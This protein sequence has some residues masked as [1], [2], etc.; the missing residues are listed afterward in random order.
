MEH[1]QEIKLSFV[2]PIYNVKPYLKKCVDSLLNQ[3]YDNY[4][5]ILV[6][7]GST[8]GS[9]LLADQLASSP[10]ASSPIIRVIH[11][12]NRGLSAAR[13]SGIDVAQGEYICFV[14]SDDYWEPNVLGG[15]MAQI[16]RDKLDVLRFKW[17]NVRLQS[18]IINHQSP[19]YEVFY[20]YKETNNRNNF[21]QAIVDGLTFLNERMSDQCYAW[22]FILKKSLLLNTNCLFTEGMLFEDTDWT[23]RMLMQAKRVASTEIVVYSYLWR[24]NG[25][26]LSK[27]DAKIRK[28][29]DDKLRLLG[30]LKQ[31][32][33]GIWYARMIAALVVSVVGILS[34]TMWI[35][36]DAY[37]NRISAL[38]VLPLTSGG[39]SKK[40]SRKICLI[41]MNLKL[42]VAM[43]HFK[44]LI[45][46][47]NH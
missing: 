7:D 35:D 32:N 11:Q 33:C 31:W 4:E 45:T 1:I 12:E 21:S 2:V 23:P 29:L 34:D 9:G 27:S 24:E 3:D 19:I 13:N 28:E 26:T 39:M 44:I 17:Q 40:M 43:L 37:V 15:L 8:D 42:A 30:N 5:I 38:Q 41:N 47:L 14:D 36:R 16:E 10:L 25:I 20:P 18:P 6:D 22:Q 46:K